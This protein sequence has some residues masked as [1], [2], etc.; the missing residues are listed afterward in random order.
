MDCIFCRILAKEIPSN[1]VYE[2]DYCYAFHDIN[3]QMPVHVVVIPKKHIVSLAEISEDDSC[4]LE[5]VLLG[6][7]KVA[8]ITGIA[9]DGY[10]VITN[11]GENGAQSV[12]HLHFHV[13]GGKKMP[14][15]IV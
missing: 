9:Q 8:E 6:C 15:Q 13:L 2:D 4:Y 10:R 7:K 1:V 3:P 12:K 5:K 11:I 14:E